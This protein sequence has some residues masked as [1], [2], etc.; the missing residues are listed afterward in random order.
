M[1]LLRTKQNDELYM[2]WV[3]RK[4]CWHVAIQCFI[5]ELSHDIRTIEAPDH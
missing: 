5:S 1:A 2:Y 4:P 3:W